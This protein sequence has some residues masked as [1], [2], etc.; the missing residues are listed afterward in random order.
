[1][2]GEIFDNLIYCLLQFCA[3]KKNSKI[4]YL[5]SNYT[6]WPIDHFKAT[7]L[8]IQCIKKENFTA[9]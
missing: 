1:M 7:L 8:K 3:L 5:L 4:I 6:R 9:P 2:F